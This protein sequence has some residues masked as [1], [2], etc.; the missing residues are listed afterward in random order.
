MIF[1]TRASKRFDIFCRCLKG[2]GHG[3]GYGAYFRPLGPNCRTPL[4]H[5]CPVWQSFHPHIYNSVSL[6]NIFKC[7]F[8]AIGR[9]KYECEYEYECAGEV[10]EAD[11]NWVLKPN[12]QK[13]LPGAS[14]GKLQLF[15][16]SLVSQVV[17]K[18]T[19]IIWYISWRISW[20]VSRNIRQGGK[21]EMRNILQVTTKNTWKWWRA[22]SNRDQ[23]AIYPQNATFS[24]YYFAT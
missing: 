9:L 2:D 7:L 13:L 15:I 12:S 8:L 1:R 6:I 20:S 21:I 11:Q 10:D 23:T 18:K 24:I 22:K 14:H 19:V 17:T 4:R 3:R 5:N 16:H